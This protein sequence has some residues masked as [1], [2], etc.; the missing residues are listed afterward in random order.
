[1]VLTLTEVLNPY[2]G[3]LGQWCYLV[4]YFNVL[5]ELRNLSCRETAATWIVDVSGLQRS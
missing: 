5:C 2:I 1:M 4:L 3:P